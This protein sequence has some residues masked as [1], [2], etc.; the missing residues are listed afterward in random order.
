MLVCSGAI[1][2]NR[3]P[4]SYRWFS[5]TG[6]RRST[7]CVPVGQPDTLINISILVLLRRPAYAPCGVIA[8]R[9]A[10]ALTAVADEGH[11]PG[12]PSG[13]SSEN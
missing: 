1:L 11:D 10:V 9:T 12:V 3:G 2:S 6:C 4:S 5:T 13:V 7:L 8:V